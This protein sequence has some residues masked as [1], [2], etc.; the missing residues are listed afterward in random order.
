MASDLTDPHRDVAE[1]VKL[2]CRIRREPAGRGPHD[3]P[4]QISE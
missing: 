3:K 2:A 1:I 4:G